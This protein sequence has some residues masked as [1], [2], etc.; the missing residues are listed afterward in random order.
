MNFSKENQLSFADTDANQFFRDHLHQAAYRYAH[1]RA[2]ETQKPLSEKSSFCQGPHR[3]E[4]NSLGFA[5]AIKKK[6]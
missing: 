2:S 3:L 1:D 6:Y 4:K 5:N